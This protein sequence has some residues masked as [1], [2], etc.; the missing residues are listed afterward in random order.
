VREKLEAYITAAVGLKR[1]NRMQCKKRFSGEKTEREN[2]ED[3]L[4]AFSAIQRRQQSA[5]CSFPDGSNPTGQ[6]PNF[7]K[8]KR[9]KGISRINGN[10]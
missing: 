1:M 6:K 7:K 9:K 10:H 4:T 2:R 5:V 3:K 8:K